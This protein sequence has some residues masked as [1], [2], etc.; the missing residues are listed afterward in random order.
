M[1]CFSLMLGAR[2]TGARGSRFKAADDKVIREI[3]RRHFPTGFTILEAHGG[4]FNPESGRFVAEE[5][6]QLLVCAP[7]PRLAAWCRELAAALHQ[8]EVLVVELGRAHR[9]QAGELR[10]TKRERGL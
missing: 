2:H 5:S 10:R 1:K 3:T 9:F 6:R 7:A 8:K 4:W